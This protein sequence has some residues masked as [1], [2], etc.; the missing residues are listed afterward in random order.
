MKQHVYTLT[1]CDSDNRGHIILTLDSSYV[2]LLQ[3][4]IYT[5]HWLAKC[6]VRDS[7]G[8]AD[9]IIEHRLGGGGMRPLVKNR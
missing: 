6:S 5:F 2:R 3:S 8:A 9:Q 4:E 1:L 7:H